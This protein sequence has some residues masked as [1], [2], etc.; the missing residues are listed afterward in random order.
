MLHDNQYTRGIILKSDK[1]DNVEILLCDTGSTISC[2]TKDVRKVST[3]IINSVYEA[4]ECSFYGILNKDKWTDAECDVIYFD[5][6]DKYDN[7]YVKNMESI[8]LKN[9]ERYLP[10]KFN[11]I[12]YG[13]SIGSGRIVNINNL[14]V[15]KGIL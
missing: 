2:K 4:I 14:I 3:H 12:L 11:V 7:F 5:V 6:I 8:T 13:Y 1:D 15:L 9:E 10:N